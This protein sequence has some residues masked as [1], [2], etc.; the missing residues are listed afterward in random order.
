[1]AYFKSSM[2]FF[3]RRIEIYNGLFEMDLPLWVICLPVWVVSRAYDDPSV[4]IRPPTLGAF[5]NFTQRQNL[6]WPISNLVFP[7]SNELCPF[8][9]EESKSIMAYF[10]SS[11]PFSNKLCP[12]LNKASKSIMAYFKWTSHFRWFLSH[13]GWSAVLRPLVRTPQSS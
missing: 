5:W 7:L 9:N 3:E 1:M 10:K 8:S 13:F 2:P 6:R 12:F 11:M 4:I